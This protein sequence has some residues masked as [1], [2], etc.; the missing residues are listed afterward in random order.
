M[1][2][3]K[4]HQICMNYL[5]MQ[6]EGHEKEKTQGNLHFD[7]GRG[8]LGLKIQKVLSSFVL[9]IHSRGAAVC[10]LCQQR[11]PCILGFASS[12][13]KSCLRAEGKAALEPGPRSFIKVV[14][15][16]RGNARQSPPSP[17]WAHSWLSAARWHCCTY[18]KKRGTR[19]GCITARE[20]AGE[21]TNRK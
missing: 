13:P 6:R 5:N 9:E 19:A 3:S 21:R 20:E 8:S 7:W 4:T 18:C 17:V 12:S 1:P 10:C 2:L 14:A 15:G 16:G 11:R